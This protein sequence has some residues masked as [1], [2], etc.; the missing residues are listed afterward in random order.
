MEAPPAATALSIDVTGR[1][2]VTNG[3]FEEVPDLV[4]DELLLVVSVPVPWL[5]LK[6]RC[7]EVRFVDAGGAKGRDECG[8]GVCG[9]VASVADG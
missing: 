2:D 4:P 6:G 8:E 5:N 3:Y 9:G 7:S 1:G